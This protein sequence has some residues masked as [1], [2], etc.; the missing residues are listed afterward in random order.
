MDKQEG[1]VTNCRRDVTLPNSVRARLE[2]LVFKCQS[3]LL[4]LL[5]RRRAA[6]GHGNSKWLSRPVSN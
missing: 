5:L 2:L 1:S 6:S 3:Q 4:T